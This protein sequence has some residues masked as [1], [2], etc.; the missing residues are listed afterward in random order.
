M[1]MIRSVMA[2]V[3]FVLACTVSVAD[4]PVWTETFDDGVGRFGQTLVWGDTLFVWDEASQRIEG[5]FR[6]D[7]SSHRRFADLGFLL[8]DDDVFGFSVVVTPRERDGFSGGLGVSGVF[9][10]FHSEFGGIQNGIGFIVRANEIPGV[11]DIRPIGIPKNTFELT[12][13]QNTAYLLQFLYDGALG[14]MEW[15]VYEGTDVTGTLL[16]SFVHDTSLATISADSLAMGADQRSFDPPGDADAW[17]NMS[18]DDFSLIGADCNGNGVLDAQD[19]ADEESNDANG[20]RVPDECECIAD[21]D[22]NGKVRVPD[23][24]I[25]L[26][27]WG[28]CPAPCPADIHGSGDGIVRLDDILLLLGSWGPCE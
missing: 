18:V 28:P 8:D 10:F 9:G 16:G 2:I 13:H 22:G 27:A 1:S 15:S 7:G 25:L 19:I 3:T 14:E 12:W 26:G 5:E 21:L 20:N 17:V 11:G 4:E 23:L 6:R 24:I